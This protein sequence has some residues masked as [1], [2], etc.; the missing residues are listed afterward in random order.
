MTEYFF[1]VNILNNL[2]DNLVDPGDRGKEI[3]P[4]DFLIS[5]VGVV[6]DDILFGGHNPFP[7]STTHTAVNFISS[8]FLR[9]GG[10]SGGGGSIP[11]G[12]VGTFT[13]SID[14]F[15]TSTGSFGLVMTANPEPGSLALCALLGAPA[16]SLLRRRRK[17]VTTD[18]AD[19]VEP[20]MI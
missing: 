1:T 4:M 20:A 6:Y 7:T 5:G 2:G 11:Y 16:L 14:V 12:G 8:T 3:G 15:P 19:L 9:F 18:V 17:P 13:F 10:L